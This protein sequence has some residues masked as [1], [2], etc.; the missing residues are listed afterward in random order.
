M[1][2]GATISEPLILSSSFLISLL[3]AYFHAKLGTLEKPIWP[4]RLIIKWIQVIKGLKR[5]NYGKEREMFFFREQ[6]MAAAFLW[7]W[8]CALVMIIVWGL[9]IKLGLSFI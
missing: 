3:I 2:E 8:I 7:F 5:E 6:Y 9:S 1:N 4:V